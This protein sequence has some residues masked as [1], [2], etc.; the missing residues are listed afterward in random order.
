MRAQERFNAWQC[1]LGEAAYG[2]GM[3]LTAVTTVL[4]L[5]FHSLGAAE[6]EI[7]AIFGIATAGWLLG[8]PFGLFML[9]RRRRGKQFLLG[10]CVVFWVPTYIAM[11]AAVHLLGTGDPP[12]CR[13]LLLVVLSVWVLGD[14]M[15]GPLWIDWLSRLFGPEARGQ[16]MGMMAWATANTAAALVAGQ[17]VSAA[18][19]P[20]GYVA[21][22]WAAAAL[23]VLGLVAYMRVADPPMAGEAPALYR[24]RDLLLRFGWSIRER[25][26]RNYLVGRVLL[27]LGGGTAGFLAVFF[28][29]PE[30]GSVPAATVIRLGAFLALAQGMASYALGWLGDRIGHKVGV[31]TGAL[32]QAAAIVIAYLG[33]GE[34]ACGACFVILG[35]AFSAG[36]VS[37]LNMLF[38]TCP[39]ENRAAHITLGSLLLSPFVMVVPVATG[40]LVAKLGWRTGIGLALV[41]TL[42]GVAWLALAVREPRAIELRGRTEQV[43]EWINGPSERLERHQDTG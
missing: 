6:F 16:A 12:L 15:I 29:R 13:A 7:G 37:H 42:M 10:W 41:P 27:T 43:S 5:L 34:L 19:F 11:G 35:V 21:L 18:A 33:R 36:W 9:G 20:H 2:A 39:H 26:F 17:F 38:E 24:G 8:Q 30:G 23:F 28:G 31:L 1:T 22:F 4:P 25:N 14:G 40:A 32:A 3:G